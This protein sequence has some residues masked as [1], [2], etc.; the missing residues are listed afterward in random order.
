MAGN[1]AVLTLCLVAFLSILSFSQMAPFYPLQ[2]REKGVGVF[3]VGFV[4]G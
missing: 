3:Y 1:S 2:A 4:L